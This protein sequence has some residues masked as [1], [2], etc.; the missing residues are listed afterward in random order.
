M[1]FLHVPS[2]SCTQVIATKPKT[3]DN[4]HAAAKVLLY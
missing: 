2:S 3:D 4:F 1:I